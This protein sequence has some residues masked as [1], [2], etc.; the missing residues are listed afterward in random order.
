MIYGDANGDGEINSKDIVAVREYLAALDYDTG[1]STV[2]VS[3]GAD[4]NGDGKI[5]L[6]DISLL[7]SYLA[8]LDYE[9]GVSSVVLGPRK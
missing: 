8:A 9:S 7:R 6:K 3:G 1:L 2:A 4:A 5:D